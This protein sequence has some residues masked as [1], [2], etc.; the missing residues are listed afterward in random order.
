MKEIKIEVWGILS[1]SRKQIMVFEMVLLSIFIG[2]TVFLFSYEFKEH[3]NNSFYTFHSKYAKYFSLACTF[4][5]IVEAQYFWSKFTKAQLEHIAEQNEKITSQ[6]EELIA[7]K[8]EI[9]ANQ[10]KIERQNR[11]I[12]DS[13][14]YAGRIQSILLPS[15]K[16]I[17]RLLTDYFL[18]FKPKDIVS[19]DFYW[20]EEYENYSIIAVADCTGHGVPGAFVSMMG[21]SFLNEIFLSAKAN[22]EIIEPSLFLNRLK[23]KLIQSVANT[24]SDQEAFDGMDISVCMI[25]KLNKSLKF[26]GALLSTYHVKYPSSKE[27]TFQLDQLKSDL[28]PISMKSY[29]H[30]IFKGI[31]IQYETGD[32]LYLASDGFSDQFG[33]E[34]GR[35]FLTLNLKN[36]L[37]SIADKSL[38]KQKEKL[39][40][41]FDKWRGSYDQ[42]DDITILGIRL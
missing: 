7:Q 17:E 24:E 40:Q 19:G 16:K 8:E 35:K 6:N 22:H 32:M 37:L 23:E 26:S 30:H 15:Q 28:H 42:L 31:E 29:G 41:K 10:Q 5:I 2:L 14:N 1:L 21:I 25:N 34:E 3:V 33:G 11:D 12:T 4:L 20:A 9:L 36:F 18:L 39:E 27:G 13:I 38:D